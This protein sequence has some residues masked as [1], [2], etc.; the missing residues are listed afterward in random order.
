MTAPHLDHQEL[1]R[2]LDA[3]GTADASAAALREH[4][5]ACAECAAALER[6]ARLEEEVDA[7]LPAVRCCPGCARASTTGD[8]VGTPARCAFC[9]VAFSPGGLKVERVLSESDHGRLYLAHGADGPVAL[10]ELVFARVPDAETLSRFEREAR[11]LEQLRHERIPRFVASFREGDGVHLRLYLAQRF[12]DG[13]ALADELEMRRFTEAD[14]RLIAREV[15]SILAD[16]QALSPPVLHRDIKPANLVRERDGTLALVDFGSARDVQKTTGG[17]L[18]G[19]FGYMPVEQLTGIVD[20]STDVYALG[21]TLVHLLTRRAPWEHSSS[22]TA[23]ELPP[24]PAVSRAFRHFLARCLAPRERRFANAK[25]AL[26]ALDAPAPNRTWLVAI[27]AA[28]LVGSAAAAPAMVRALRR[29]PAAPSAVAGADAGVDGSAAQPQEMERDERQ[30]L[31]HDDDPPA[32]LPPPVP[33][34]LDPVT[35]HIVDVI[36]CGRATGYA[37]V[38]TG[39]WV[40]APDGKPNDVT[41]NATDPV[42]AK[43]LARAIHSWRFPEHSGGDVGMTVPFDFTGAAGVRRHGSSAEKITMDL[44]DADIRNALR[45]VAEVGKKN[46]VISDDVRGKVTL[47]LQNVPWDQVLDEIV[48][49]Q[50]LVAAERDGIISVTTMTSPLQSARRR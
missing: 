17:T 46:M 2:L 7:L 8:D 6:E 31:R 18:V 29:D 12:V 27:A 36:A 20:E 43:C 14:A 21:A 42:L 13:P 39:D 40:V 3:A 15:L 22:T 35:E 49:T 45:L 5:R 1:A 50:G 34:P 23:G 25:A 38:A 30:A 33:D 24:L 37:G 10:K 32:T 47:K 4:V 48:R 28:A 26:A 44:L 41:V 11:L 19:T 9:G 16:L